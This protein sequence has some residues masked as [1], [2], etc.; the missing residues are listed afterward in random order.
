MTNGFGEWMQDEEAWQETDQLHSE[1]SGGD[2][3]SLKD[4]QEA[5]LV[6]QGKPH[7]FRSVW[8]GGKSEIYNPN[9]PEHEGIRPSGRYNWPVAVKADGREYNP[10][11]FESSGQTYDVIKE[12]LSEYG[13]RTVFKLK[14]KGAGTDTSYMCLFQ[15][16]LESGE[17]EH[18]ASLEK[19]P[20]EPHANNG[21][22]PSDVPEAGESPW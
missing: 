19:L 11:V 22:E 3:L 15:R 17:L 5:I 6:V 8:I 7:G 12:A 18:V 14:R 21:S 13:P 2:F 4:G 1:T 20:T 9:N 10:K 16:K